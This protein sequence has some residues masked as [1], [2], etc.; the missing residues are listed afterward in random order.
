MAKDSIVLELQ[1]DALDPAV[2]VSDLLRKA[3][4]VASKLE[5]RDLET[6]INSE[7]NGYPD[8]PDLN[9][10]P[11][12]RIVGEVKALNPFHGWVPLHSKEPRILELLT[13][14]PCGQRVAELEHLLA[15]LGDGGHLTMPLPPETQV[16]L[17]KGMNYRAQVEV[18]IS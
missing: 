1:R 8:E 10:P 15:K 18:F 7:L 11:Y 5:Q 17:Q 12:R 16:N 4:V 13:N 2:P 14:R 3:L 9:V 6:W